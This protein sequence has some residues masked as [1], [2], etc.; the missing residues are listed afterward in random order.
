MLKLW[1]PSVIPCFLQWVGQDVYG[2]AELSAPSGMQRAAAG[3]L[4]VTRAWLTL[5]RQQQT[6][7]ADIY[8]FVLLSSL[9]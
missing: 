1:K 5:G 6:F 3:A 2:Q 9:L 4:Q 7:F 8:T